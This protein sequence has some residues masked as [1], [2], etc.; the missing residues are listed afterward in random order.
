MHLKCIFNDDFFFYFKR[1]E[2]CLLA[3]LRPTN[4]PCILFAYVS[5]SMNYKTMNFELFASL[6]SLFYNVK[7]KMPL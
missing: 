5:V 2:P 1:A 6:W 7:K 3:F 4:L